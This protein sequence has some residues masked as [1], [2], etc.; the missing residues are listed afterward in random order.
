[1]QYYAVT[2]RRAE[3][4]GLEWA[5]PPA[6]FLTLHGA[7]VEGMGQAAVYR[8]KDWGYVVAPTNRRPFGFDWEDWGRL[9][10]LEV[11][12]LARERYDVAADRVYLTGHSMGGHGTWHLGVTYPDRWVAIGPSAGWRSFWSYTGAARYEDATPVEVILKRSTNP[13][14]TIALSRNLLHGGVYILHGADDD[15]VPADQARF[16]HEHLSGFHPDVVYHEQPGAGHWWGNQCCDWDPMF[17]F[18]AARERPAV[19]ERIEFHTASPGVSAGSDWIAVEQQRAI[20]DFSAVIADLDRSARR[21][22]ATTT[23]VARLAVDLAPLADDGTSPV[24]VVI[25]GQEVRDVPWPE[26][27]T[28]VAFTAGEGGW[29]AAATPLAAAEKGP[30]RYGQFKDAFRHRVL[31]V[32]GTTGTPAENAWAFAK[33][34]F[35]AETF[36][37][38]GNASIEIVPDTAF[39]PDKQRDRSVILYGNADTN[40]A[41]AALLGASPVQVRR[42]AIALGD[43]TWRGDDLGALLIRPRPGSDVASVGAVTGSGPAGMRLTDRLPYFVSGVAYPDVVVL[44]PEALEA[45]TAGVRAVGNFGTDWSVGSG[46]FAFADE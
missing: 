9:D 28:R 33:A 42:G 37:Y 19:R 45:G 3:P 44:G 25:D 8:H 17:E 26:K 23:N 13:S 43:R 18:F 32:H 35:D 38:R 10:A 40:G 22:T 30:H 41:W 34:R 21:V 29:S 46:E 31:F 20:M 1:V 39:D 7:S 5:T 11:L 12:A 36:W 24:T 6:L 2:P 4:A 16:M 27:G 15:N 14:D